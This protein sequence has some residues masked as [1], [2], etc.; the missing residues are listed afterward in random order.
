M[1]KRLSYLLGE[2]QREVDSMS[3]MLD[4]KMQNR[5]LNAT[6]DTEVSSITPTPMI[7]N[8][9]PVPFAFPSSIVPMDMTYDNENGYVIKMDVPGLTGSGITVTIEPGNILTVVGER[10]C[11]TRRMMKDMDADTDT[12]LLQRIHLERYHGKFA[13]SVKLPD[14]IDTKN[15]DA[16]VHNG[17]LTIRIGKKN[18]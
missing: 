13:R 1:F 8:V 5:I 11:N 7:D 14:D 2:M 6:E 10:S 15:V 17:I 4:D 18:A 3:R 9:M 12:D 16:C